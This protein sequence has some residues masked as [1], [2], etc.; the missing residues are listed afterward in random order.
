MGLLDNILGQVLGKRSS[1]DNLANAVMGL[2]G[3]QQTGGL[4]GLVKQF[5]SK[6]LGDVINSWVSTGQNLPITA[7]QL[8]QGLGSNTVKQLA[9]QAGVSS[10]QLISQLTTLLPT[11]IDKLTPNG[12]LPEGDIMS[13]GAS[14]LKSLL[15]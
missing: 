9:S 15:K 2:L 8:Q 6:G 3:N 14:L 1:Q 10:D 5:A 4:E 13:Q 7:Q 11:L 12:K